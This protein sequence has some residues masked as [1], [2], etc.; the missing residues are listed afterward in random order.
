M[1][2]P[3]CLVIKEA[4]KMRHSVL[5]NTFQRPD[6]AFAV[7]RLRQMCCRWCYPPRFFALLT[8]PKSSQ[9]RLSD[10]IPLEAQR[11][12][13]TMPSKFVNANSQK[14]AQNKFS[15]LAKPHSSRVHKEKRTHA[16]PPPPN[17]RGGKEEPTLRGGTRN[18]RRVFSMQQGGS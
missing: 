1:L 12:Y 6:G 14:V 3:Q 9:M 11:P 8:S 10:Q 5:K 2:F 16:A 7:G 18:T 4:L 17:Q 13:T 15:F